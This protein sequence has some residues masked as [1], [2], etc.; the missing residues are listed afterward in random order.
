MNLT[1]K[2]LICIPW[3]TE[4]QS[5]IRFIKVKGVKEKMYHK[6]LMILMYSAFLKEI[7]VILWCIFHVPIHNG[8]VR[9]ERKCISYVLGSFKINKGGRKQQ[10][11]VVCNASDMFYHSVST[12]ALSSSLPN[13]P[14]SAMLSGHC[15]QGFWEMQQLSD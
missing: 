9:T 1:K 12:I 8:P 15:A 13:A 10:L 2:S 11:I 14:S 6:N 4:L 7:F 5:M 3:E